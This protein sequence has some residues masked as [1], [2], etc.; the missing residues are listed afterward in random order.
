[1]LARTLAVGLVGVIGTGLPASG[2]DAG[3]APLAEPAPLLE[4]HTQ[5]MGR[6]P[7]D[8]KDQ[9]LYRAFAML[10]DRLDDLAREVDMDD[11]Q[12]GAMALAWDLLTSGI[13]V[14]VTEARGGPGFAARAV[15][16]PAE[17]TDAGSVLD[18]VL[19]LVEFAG[20][21]IERDAGSA[22]LSTPVGQADLSV[23]EGAL[24]LAVGSSPAL[25]VSI[26]RY[27]LP[28]G[29]TPIASGQ[30]DIGGLIR[31]FAPDSGQGI[32]ELTRMPGGA[33]FAALLG[34][35][36][37]V[38]T[39][40]IGVD[41][42]RAHAVSVSTGALALMQTQGYTL[43]GGFSREDF[44]RVPADAVRVVATPVA[45]GQLVEAFDALEAETGENP[46][47]E[48]DE[49]LGI[50]L[51]GDVLANV[52]PEMLVYQSES[53]G[54]GGLTSTVLIANVSDPA[55]LGR[56]HARIVERANEFGRGLARGY[57]RVR[58]F[59][60]DGVAA[61]TLNTPGIPIPLDPAWTILNGKLVIA[62]SPGSLTA[63]IH[64]MR[65]A[66]TSVLDNPLFERAVGERMP[67]GRVAT[68]TFTDAPRLSR[69]GYGLTKMLLAGVANGVRSPADPDRVGFELMPAY[70]EFVEGIEP[71]GSL[72]WWQGED[73]WSHSVGDRSVTVQCAALA[74]SF[75]DV[76]AVFVPALAAGVILPALG[77][78]RQAAQEVKSATQVRS[79]AQAVVVYGTANNDRGP[80]SIQQLIE[81][82]LIDPEI[83]IS[84]H[85]PAI[86]GG[87]DITV[88]LDRPGMAMS[89]NGQYILAIDRAMLVN[90]HPTVN[91]GF[92]DSHVE[93][94]DRA[95]LRIMLEQPIN[96]GAAAALQL[97]NF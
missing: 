6:W 66:D 14:R 52:G 86:D 85:G 50:D 1:M 44:A 54:G 37:P 11:A 84:P 38:T 18:E 22:Q 24:R 97:P 31:V 70:H 35:D 72:S 64:Q 32:E 55:A 3:G 67:E 13:A 21:P 59:D 65:G 95:T 63:A 61:F 43:G 53:T 96:E 2:Q 80:E 19:G 28:E 57:A 20:I 81:V 26:P 47:R 10:G 25:D 5:G 88:R 89:F 23:D 77:Q 87:P 30:A 9:G 42:R 76:Q 73:L 12:A 29:V 27:D 49:M 79:V 33:M 58:T 39:F 41:D 15:F 92:A 91:V 82:G 78:A 74:G 4:L 48:V 51:A 46:L 69:R 60:I 83:L 71:S 45:T 16:S 68:L 94:M 40:A 62:L 17:G 8:P 75:A 90:G 36:A 93:A 34:P 7:V 56:A